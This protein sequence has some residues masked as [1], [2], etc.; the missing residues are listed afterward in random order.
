MQ[1][2]T[3]QHSEKEILN[4]FYVLFRLF[5]E[6][7]RVKCCDKNISNSTQEDGLPSDLAEVRIHLTATFTRS[8]HL[9]F[10]SFGFYGK[11]NQEKIPASE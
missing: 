5:R 2:F 4:I 7:H 9:Q 6:T 3:S 8:E 1:T 11:L 10:L